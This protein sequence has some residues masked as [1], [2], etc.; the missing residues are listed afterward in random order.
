MIFRM[1]S[2]VGRV[3]T[4]DLEPNITGACPR[5]AMK[6]NWLRILLFGSVFELWS[7]SEANRHANVSGSVPHG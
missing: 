6:L 3:M 7:E 5:V 2:R 1:K 4:L